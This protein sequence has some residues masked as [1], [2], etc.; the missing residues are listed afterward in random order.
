MEGRGVVVVVRVRVRGEGERKGFT[1]L[2]YPPT[3]PPTLTPHLAP[4]PLPTPPQ[5]RSM[6]GRALAYLVL[7]LNVSARLE[8]QLH[9]WVMA[10]PCREVQ[11]SARVLR[12]EL[13][14]G[15]REGEGVVGG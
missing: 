13:G 6:V 4:P 9:H 15:V 11:G 10:L 3:A 8:Q 12:E 1:T 7:G 2:P 14:M 5:R